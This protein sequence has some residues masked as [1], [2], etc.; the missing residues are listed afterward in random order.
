[1]L[2]LETDLLANHLKS[3]S[4][5]E[6]REV[7]EVEAAGV[8]ALQDGARKILGVAGFDYFMGLIIL[9]NVIVMVAEIDESAKEENTNHENIR[10]AEV[11]GW[12]VLTV[13]IFEL[14][15]RLVSSQ[16]TFWKD[17]WNVGDFVIVVA[18]LVF[19]IIGMVAGDAFPVSILRVF[20]LSKLARVSKVLRIFPELKMLLAGLVHSVRAV[21]WGMLLLT[22]FLLV[23]S[24]VAV[25][26]IHPLN[27]T[28]DYGD[29]CDRC[30]R[31]YSSVPQAALTFF[32]IVVTGDSWGEYTVPL[33]EQHPGTILFFIPVFMCI[34]LSIMNLMLAVVVNQAQAAYE[35][36]AEV[37]ET[38][39]ALQKMRH[40]DNVVTLCKRMDADNSGELSHD[41]L[42]EGFK[43]LSEFRDAMQELG[44][45]EGDFEIAWSIMDT[46]KT[47][48]VS[49]KEFVSFLV[50]MKTSDSEFLLAYIKNCITWIKNTLTRQME[51]A[52]IE[53]Q[54]MQNKLREAIDKVEEE[55]EA[56]QEDERV[57][58]TRQRTSKLEGVVSDSNQDGNLQR[59]IPQDRNE[60]QEKNIQDWMAYQR[61]Q[62]VGMEGQPCVNEGIDGGV[63][64][65]SASMQD[66]VRDLAE[67]F[68]YDVFRMHLDLKNMLTDMQGNLCRGILPVSSTEHSSS[69][70]K[71]EL[72]SSMSTAVS[73]SARSTADPGLRGRCAADLGREFRPGVMLL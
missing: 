30:S 36:E 15:M 50:T 60:K 31:A 42:F 14:I 29:E 1:M 5:K 48:T 71:T 3:I 43:S 64:A 23:F 10:W 19:S 34:G 6:L 4:E 46:H 68:S 25:L 26:V 69:K 52:R 53:N 56:I 33:L 35:S 44:V 24:M 32:Q 18:D 65:M 22:L 41:E 38:E 63:P 28:V 17:P 9:A 45:T 7:E 11:F 21:F 40:H 49:Y 57:I 73:S 12:V 59:R 55:E 13:F 58:L 8:N 51:L 39:K 16:C 67:Q 66:V 61:Q 37:E 70:T 62:N 54:A 72:G 27:K 47:G 20:R 2:K